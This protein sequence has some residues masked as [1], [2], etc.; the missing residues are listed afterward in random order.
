LATT[1]ASATGAAGAAGGFWAKT[2]GA[3]SD[4]RTSA[5]VAALTMQEIVMRRL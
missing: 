2:A 3:A 5:R 1:V 4:T